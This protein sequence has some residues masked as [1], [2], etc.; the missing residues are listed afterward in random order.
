M[1]PSFKIT[2]KTSENEMFELTI[3]NAF[4]FDATVAENVTRINTAARNILTQNAI[5]TGCG[6]LS[7][8]ESIVFCENDMVSY[9][10]SDL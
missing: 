4:D 3:P 7:S 9:D 8:V 2:Y 6:N 1:N 10:V 5:Q